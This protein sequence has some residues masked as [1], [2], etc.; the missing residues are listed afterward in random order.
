[1]FFFSYEYISII[2]LYRLGLGNLKGIYILQLFGTDFAREYL[3]EIVVK[4]CNILRLNDS[5]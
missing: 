2:I 4:F 1:V 5:F 3:Y